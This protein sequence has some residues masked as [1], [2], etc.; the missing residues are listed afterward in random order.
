[1]KKFYSIMLA[2]FMFLT[3]I[4]FISAEEGTKT[5]YV[6]MGWMECI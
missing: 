5:F 6:M 1:M 4:T 2:M 3:N